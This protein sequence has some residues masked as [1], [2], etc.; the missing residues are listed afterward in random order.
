MLP[1]DDLDVRMT[2]QSDVAL[3]RFRLPFC[4]ARPAFVP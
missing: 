2:S 1:A 4:R 3:P